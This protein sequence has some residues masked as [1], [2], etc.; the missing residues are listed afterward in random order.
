M[1]CMIKEEYMY[2]FFIFCFN[3][4]IF[5]FNEFL[6]VIGIDDECVLIN[7]FVVD[8]K[9]VVFLLLYLELKKY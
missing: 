7:V 3:C 5:G 9:N 2:L 6:F 4:E 1:I 8:F